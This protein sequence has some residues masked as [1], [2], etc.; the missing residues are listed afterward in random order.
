MHTEMVWMYRWDWF[1]GHLELSWCQTGCH[2]HVWHFCLLLPWTRCLINSPWEASQV[3]GTH[4][5]FSALIIKALFLPSIFYLYLQR[6]IVFEDSQ[7][8][9]KKDLQCRLLT[10]ESHTRQLELKTKNYADQSKYIALYICHRHGLYWT[11]SII[12]KYK[13][14]TQETLWAASTGLVTVC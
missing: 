6:Y 9:E 3:C 14:H 7:E 5:C 1:W 10:L 2:I 8:G 4:F 13:T 12:A 11:G